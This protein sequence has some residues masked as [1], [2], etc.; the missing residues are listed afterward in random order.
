M[1]GALIS[2]VFISPSI[3]CSH[4][5]SLIVPG[6]A[7]RVWVSW[8]FTH[9]Q[10]SHKK[11]I[12]S[13]QNKWPWGL[14]DVPKPYNYSSYVKLTYACYALMRCSTAHCF[15]GNGIALNSKGNDP[16]LAAKPSIQANFYGL[17]ECQVFPVGHLV[18]SGYDDFL[19]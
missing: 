3:H 16:S 19:D 7:S 2:R 5:L 1:G 13:T 4:F 8:V 15:I 10:V 9:F 18:L 12:S 17:K 11:K 14:G 6:S